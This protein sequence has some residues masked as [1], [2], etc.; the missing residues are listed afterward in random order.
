VAV[1]ADRYVVSESLSEAWLDAVRCLY[2]TNGSKAVHLLVRILNPICE[3][4]EIRSEA[5]GLI[6]SWNA[7]HAKHMY[8]IETTRNTL[9]PAAWARRHP[10]PED[11]ARYYNERYLRGGDLR[12]IQNNG[13]GTYFGRIVAYPRGGAESSDQLNETVRK[14]RVELAARSTKS[15]RYE[16]N[17]FCEATDTSSTSFPCLAHLSFHLHEGRLHAQAIYRNESLVGRGYGN[18]LGIAELQSYLANCVGL[19]LGELLITAGH[20]ELDGSRTAV[21]EMLERLRRDDS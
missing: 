14:L 16:I 17:I 9:F 15:S 11:L 7:S 3:V 5:Q 19:Q 6:E 13:R 8:D 12:S 18:Y 4:S 10:D 21:R 20:V 1:I 2:D